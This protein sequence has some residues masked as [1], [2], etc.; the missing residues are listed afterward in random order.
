MSLLVNSKVLAIL[1]YIIVVNDEMHSRQINLLN[2]VLE[3]N[4]WDN[5][6]EVV[7]DILND[8]DER[9]KLNEALEFINNETLSAQ[10]VIYHVCYQLAIIDHDSFEEKFID[11]GEKEILNRIEHCMSIINFSKERKVAYRRLK[12]YI[13]RE[14]IGNDKAMFNLDFRKL[15]KLARS[16]FDVMSDTIKKLLCEC[17]LLDRRL[18]N[19]DEIKNSKLKESLNEFR[20]AYKENVLIILEKLREILPQK[21]LASQGLSLALMGR[22]KAGKSTL[23]S[24]MC[25]EGEEFIGKGGQR[26]TRFNR[27]FSWKGIKIID[28][29]GIGA[30]E[31]S[32]KKDEEVARRVISQADVI[33]FVIADDTIAEDILDMLDDIVSYH[34]PIIILLNHKD[35]INKKSHLKKFLNNPNHW[36]D[37]EGEQNLSG[38]IERL[39]RNAT[40]KGYID[41]INIVPVFLLA[42]IKGIKEENRV[43]F[44]PSNFQQFIE[45]IEQMVEKNCMIYKSQ[46]MLDEPSVQLYKSLE[47]L[48][49]EIEKLSLF[50]TKIDGIKYRTMNTMGLIQKDVKRNVQDSIET[51]FDTFFTEKCDIYVDKNYNEKSTFQLQKSYEELRNDQGIYVY[52]QQEIDEIMQEYHDKIS[53]VVRELEKEIRYANINISEAI[54]FKYINWLKKNK[55]II[56]VKGILKF[57]S[58]GLD[59]A[60]IWFPALCIISIPLSFFSGFFKSK[61]QKIQNAKSLTKDNFDKLIQHDRKQVEKHINENLNRIFKEDKSE[62]VIFFEE[63]EYALQEIMLYIRQCHNEFKDSLKKMDTYFAIRILEFI[64]DGAGAYTFSFDNVKVNRLVESNSFEIQTKVGEYFNTSK[65]K[66]ITGENVKVRKYI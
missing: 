22:T 11:S 55:E 10:I 18:N 49:Y 9:V 7:Y 61:N 65:I 38:W 33:C 46:T 8:K 60:S 36:K 45:Q 56:P 34:K 19:I 1:G 31:A 40:K 5:E 44:E 27:V 48:D 25:Q 54:D 24:I 15:N 57:I 21:E 51:Q 59:V 3:S 29:P 32:G 53:D 66:K 50:K 43:F 28:T 16:D 62:L 47:F 26:T 37:T 35:D 14:K 6:R 17:D 2:S 52:I 20:M 4:D 23:H 42:A 13:S 64:T 12:N 39:K 30:G 41:M 58:M 63:L